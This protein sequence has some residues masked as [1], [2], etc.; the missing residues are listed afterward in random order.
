MCAG[1]LTWKGLVPGRWD[2]KGEE[3]NLNNQ[4][5]DESM[6]MVK[7]E[8]QQRL[9]LEDRCQSDVDLSWCHTAQAPL[10]IVALN[11]FTENKWLIS[12]GV[13][14][15]YAPLGVKQRLRC[16]IILYKVH[17]SEGWHV[18]S[19]FTSDRIKRSHLGSVLCQRPALLWTC[20]VTSLLSPCL[21]LCLCLS[22]SLSLLL[23]PTTPLV[24]QTNMVWGLAGREEKGVEFEVTFKAWRGGCWN[25]LS[26]ERKFGD[27][28][29]FGLSRFSQ[30]CNLDWGFGICGCLSWSP[31]LQMGDLQNLPANRFVTIDVIF[32]KC[33]VS[34]KE[35]RSL[36]WLGVR[37][38]ESWGS[39]FM[40]WHVVHTFLKTLFSYITGNRLGD[41]PSG[42]CETLKGIVYSMRVETMLCHVLSCAPLWLACVSLHMRNH[43]LSCT[44][45]LT[46]SLKRRLYRIHLLLHQCIFDIST[47]H[48]HIH[49]H[50]G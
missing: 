13:P 2:Q 35:V 1:W 40:A 32:R 26:K 5:S 34:V 45:F 39:R 27:C 50:T 4:R 29:C 11:D 33:N 9:R 10:L 28:R 12:K 20:F 19:S 48:T 31:K 43:T 49:T 6:V 8:A 17:Y 18:E 21:P 38:P 44:P 16:F 47:F 41:R 23:H 30:V 15:G 36:A 3:I 24:L 7:G 46:T 25:L 22:L 42:T 37:V 14:K